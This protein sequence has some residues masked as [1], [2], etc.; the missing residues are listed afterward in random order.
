MNNT[1]AVEFFRIYDRKIMSGE[2]SFSQT[3]ISKEDFSR[4][5]TEADFVISR[6]KLETICD[7][8]DLTD[9]ETE[10]LMS[11]TSVK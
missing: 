10:L 11:Y 3:G 7:R 5:C 9:S 4:L 1:F 2:I 8:M 6:E